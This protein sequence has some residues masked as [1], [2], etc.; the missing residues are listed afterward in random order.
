MGGEAEFKLFAGS[1]IAEVEIDVV[2]GGGGSGGFAIDPFDGA[3]FDGELVEL[4]GGGAGGFRGGG[5]FAERFVVPVTL[6]IANEDDRRLDE[7]EGVDVNLFSKEGEEADADRDEFGGGEGLGGGEGGGFADG[8]V[9]DADGEGDDLEAHVAEGDG[10]VEALFKLPG[11][12]VV[13][14]VDIDEKGEGKQ[15]GCEEKEKRGKDEEN[16]AH[17]TSAI[18]DKLS[19]AGGPGREDGGG[20]IREE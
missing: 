3:V 20:G 19:A 18:N 6:R 17:E 1:E 13:V 7:A 15:G 4:D 12:E 11:D 10:A 2:V 16:A 5:G 9:F 14:L 8:D